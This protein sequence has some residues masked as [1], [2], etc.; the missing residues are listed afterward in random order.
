M[1]IATGNEE[2]KK[3]VMKQQMSTNNPI[4][5]RSK[6]LTNEGLSVIKMPCKHVARDEF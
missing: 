5:L 3:L 4:Q 1:S 6:T 2:V